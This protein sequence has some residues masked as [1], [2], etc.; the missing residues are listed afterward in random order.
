[1]KS[2]AYKTD[3][4]EI[5]A[6]LLFLT[7][8]VSIHF[9]PA[10]HHLIPIEFLTLF[11]LLG[12][13]S[14]YVT[15]IFIKLRFFYYVVILQSAAAFTAAIVWGGVHKDIGMVI[16]G[17]VLAVG[18]LASQVRRERIYRKTGKRDILPAEGR[19]AMVLVAGAFLALFG[20]AVSLAALFPEWFA[21]SS[22]FG[23]GGRLI[24]PINGIL[25]S[26][27]GGGLLASEL[28]AWKGIKRKLISWVSFLS[29]SL[30]AYVF[31]R[32]GAEGSGSLL[33][34]F[35]ALL[36]MSEYW[37]FFTVFPRGIDEAKPGPNLIFGYEYAGKLGLWTTI[38]W[39]GVYF[40]L[41]EGLYV[42]LFF[43]GVIISTLIGVVSYHVVPIRHYTHQKYFLTLIGLIAPY[44]LLVSASGGLES[45]F[46]PFGMLLIFAGTVLSSRFVWIPAVIIF[47]ILTLDFLGEYITLGYISLTRG[48][49]FVF[50]AAAIITA[51]LFTVVISRRRELN[52]DELL[53]A[54][55]ELERTLSVFVKTKGSSELQA[56]RFRKANEELVEMR[57][58]LMNVLED[59]ETSKRIIEID[60]LREKAIF[61]ALGEGVVATDKSGKV[62][63]FNRVASE[64]TGIPQEKAIG[65]QLEQALLLYEE[66]KDV[67]STNAFVSA[68]SG[69]GS[70]LLEGVVVHA[71][72]GSIVPVAGTVQ[73]YLDDEERLSGIVAAFRDITIEKEI[74]EQKSG[75]ISVASHQLRTP[76]S[77][78]R[79][80]VDLLLA[81]DAGRLTKQQREFLSDVHSSIQ[82]LASLV[83]DLLNVSRAESGRLTYASK[84]VDLKPLIEQLVR[85]LE[86]VIQEKKQKVEVDLGK[87][88]PHADV[89]PKLFAQVIENLIANAVKY[90]PEGG[91]VGIRLSS[92]DTKTLL[93]EIWDTGFGIEKENQHKIFQKF[94]RGKRAVTMETVGTGLGLYIAKTVVDAGGGKIWFE[95]EEGKG[96]KFFVTLPVFKGKGKL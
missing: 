37:D 80:Y 54:N 71:A 14:S 34:V 77:A 64:I 58:A 87:E 43:F 96:T 8:A 67:I 36:I 49:Q 93:L 57:A 82:R 90:T 5:S 70:D 79:W 46:V 13:G 17:V 65:K 6:G 50:I 2:V 69:T 31:V 66:D 26:L 53:E 21:L 59:V 9:T 94:Y 33:G 40:V 74:A 52:E 83:D 12:T 23:D 4:L 81:G 75:F 56:E 30:L 44:A 35:A 3:W 25:I 78:M 27:I 15:H 62:I 68:L 32:S 61:Q 92:K 89:D 16:F 51:S 63:L 38:A 85:E 11:F 48:T 91:K 76:L 95:S 20:V 10:H 41:F 55:K 45:P 86:G 22:V 18:V 60:H 7:L 1:M 29:L 39:T 47:A 73:P 24:Y 72:G 88:L 28:H 84:E 19:E 42:N